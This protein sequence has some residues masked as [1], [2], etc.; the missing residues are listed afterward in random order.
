MVYFD[1]ILHTHACQQCVTTDM[2]NSLFDGRGSPAGRGQLVK[3]LITLV[4][5]GRIE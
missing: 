5:H 2:R 1:Q 3:M 4:P